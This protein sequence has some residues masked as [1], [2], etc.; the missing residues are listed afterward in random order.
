MGTPEQR[1]P[2]HTLLLLLRPLNTWAWDLLPYTLSLGD[3]SSAKA[4][5][6]SLAPA[7]SNHQANFSSL[8]G[9]PEGQEQHIQKQSLSI[10]TTFHWWMTVF[11]WQVTVFHE[12]MAAFYW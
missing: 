12:R 11:H 7:A 5:M 4:S 2:P 6:V 9:C 8:L 3:H 1:P 10:V